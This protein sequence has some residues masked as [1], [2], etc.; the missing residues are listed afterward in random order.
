MVY[1]HKV[2]A[3]REG[4]A[5][6]WPPDTAGEDTLALLDRA[7]A[8]L[9]AEFAARKPDE[10]SY[11]WYEPEQTVGFW[12]R[13]MA[14]ETV[15]HRVDA[16]LALTEPFAEIPD[17][18][19]VDGVDEVLERFLGYGSVA[20]RA[21]F[22]PVLPPAVEDQVLLRAGGRGWLVR[23]TPGGV[24]VGPATDDQPFSATVEGEP[25]PLLLWLW[26]RA[27]DGVTRTGD[28]RLIDLLWRL[29]GAAT[30]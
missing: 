1:L 3:M 29:F 9:T 17:D 14:Q 27:D 4:A 23:A 10:P 6:E 26:R 18:L 20:W 19:A 8:E 22:A 12:I 24:E 21:D 15:I 13:R 7:Y 25:A 28:P 11:T 2:G 16:E 30:Q 5:Q